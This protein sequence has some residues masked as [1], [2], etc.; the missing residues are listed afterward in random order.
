MIKKFTS[1]SSYLILI[2]LFFSCDEILDIYPPELTVLVPQ[3]GDLIQDSIYV[4]LDVADAD[5]LKK[6]EIITLTEYGDKFTEVSFTAAPF[7]ASF[8]VWTRSIDQLKIKAV[9]VN[10]NFDEKII[11]LN[12]SIMY[13]VDF[14]S[15]EEYEGWS[16]INVYTTTDDYFSGEQ[17]VMIYSTNGSMSVTRT[18][19]EGTIN[20]AYRRGSGCYTIQ[21]GVSFLIDGTAAWSLQGGDVGIENIDGINWEE[22]EIA[23]SAGEHVL[24]W[25]FEHECSNYDFLLLDAIH[26]P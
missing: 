19:R 23:V 14:E 8:P 20:F 4:E 3:N 22:Q 26:L 2:L 6:V 5:D 24:E 15:D 25:Q 21:P 16:F 1:F 9:D 10:G 18:C 7:Q 17:C 13:D 11:S 12:Q